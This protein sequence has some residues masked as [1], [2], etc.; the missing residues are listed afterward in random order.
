MLGLVSSGLGRSDQDPTLTDRPPSPTQ[1]WML[2]ET[3]LLLQRNAEK[4]EQVLQSE[5]AR[6]YNNKAYLGMDS[7]P[8]PPIK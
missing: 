7:P 3:Q 8:H 1:D 4:Q 2:S 6:R 5:S